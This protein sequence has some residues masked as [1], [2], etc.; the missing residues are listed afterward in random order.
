M[1]SPVFYA[2]PV[3]QPQSPFKRSSACKWESSIKSCGSIFWC[4]TRNKSAS[5][6]LSEDYFDFSWN[7]VK[8]TLLFLVKRRHLLKSLTWID[9]EDVGEIFFLVWVRFEISYRNERSSSRQ[10][11]KYGGGLLLFSCWFSRD[12]VVF[13]GLCVNCKF[14]WVKWSFPKNIMSLKVSENSLLRTV[15]SRLYFCI[16]IN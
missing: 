7:Q 2:K 5:A 14:N 12:L 15:C 9:V 13:F 16:I 10:E 11:M 1:S 3:A 6:Q 4:E 8:I